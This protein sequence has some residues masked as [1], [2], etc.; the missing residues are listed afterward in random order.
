MKQQYREKQTVTPI[1]NNTYKLSDY[2]YSHHHHHLT[3][4]EISDSEA[5]T[6]D[7]GEGQCREVESADKER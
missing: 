7:G 6:V 3:I 4:F 1:Y 2:L 5:G